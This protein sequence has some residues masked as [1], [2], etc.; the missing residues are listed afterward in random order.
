MK[1]NQTKIWGFDFPNLYNSYINPDNQKMLSIQNTEKPFTD[2]FNSLKKYCL[3]GE[4]FKIGDTTFKPKFAAFSIVCS[5]C[6]K[7]FSGE[8]YY[9][10]RSGTRIELLCNECST[11]EF[12][13][14]GIKI[15]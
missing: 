6:H 9:E 3:P 4:E 15:V 10:K 14:R 11:D 7:K 8:Q 5:R 12:N 1:L 2:T 13:K